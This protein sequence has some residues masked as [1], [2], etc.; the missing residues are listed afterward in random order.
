MSFTVLVRVLRRIVRVHDSAHAVMLHSTERIWN[1]GQASTAHTVRHA[2]PGCSLWWVDIR[3][4]HLCKFT[5]GRNGFTQWC[6]HC[7]G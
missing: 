1:T 4:T 3:A 6:V 5:S 7:D 2:A